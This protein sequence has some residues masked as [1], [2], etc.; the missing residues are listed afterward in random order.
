MANPQTG[1]HGR[2]PWDDFNGTP[3]VQAPAAGTSAVATPAAVPDPWAD[4]YGTPVATPA[5]VQA[6][7]SL[8]PGQRTGMLANVGAAVQEGAAGLVNIA[9]DPVGNIIGKPVVAAG[10]SLYNLGARAFGYDKLTSEQMSAALDDGPGPGDALVAGV[11]RAAGV[12]T[13]ADVVPSTD[14]QHYARAGIQGAVGMAALGPLG[15]LRQIAGT[16]ATGAVSGAGS[17]LAQ[18]ALPS[19]LAPGGA[20]LGGIVAPMLPAVGVTGL[21]GAAGIVKNPLMDYVGP[22]LKTGRNVLADVAPGQPFTPENAFTSESGAPLRASA[23]QARAAGDRLQGA[24]QDPAAT[25]QALAAAPPMATTSDGRP[26]GPTT[27]QLTRDPGLQAAEQDAARGPAAGDF[28]ARAAAQNDANVGAIRGI[29]DGADPAALPGALQHQADETAALHDARVDQ[30]S[31][32]MADDLAAI[33]AQADATRTGLGQ[34][35]DQALQAIGGNLPAGSEAQV[36]ASL[37]APLDTANQAARGSESELW[38]AIDP[39]GTLN[40]DMQPVRAKAQEI[41]RG[42]GP[43]AAPLAGDEAAIMQTAAKLPDV[44]SFRDLADLRGRLTDTIRQERQANGSTPAVA[45]MSQLL[46]GVHEAMTGAANGADLAP[47]ADAAPR[48][49][50]A[51]VAAPSVGGEVFTPSGQRSDVRYEVVDGNNLVTSH[52]HR[53]L[54]PNPA[55]PQELQPRQRERAVSE[56]QVAKIASQL[57][58]ERLGASST[59]A[60]GAPIV[61]PDNLVESGNGRVMGLRRAYDANGPQAQ[62]YRDWL[63]GQGHDTTGMQQPMLIR[64]R[65][66]DMTPE[67]RVAFTREGSTPTTLALSATERAAGDAQRLPDDVLQQVRPGDVAD[68]SNRDFVRGFLQHAVEPGQEG[69]FVTADGGLSQEGAARVRAAL[70]H[71]AYG[72]QGLSAALAETIDPMARVMAGAMQDAVGPMARLRAGIQSG[73]VDPAVDIAPALVEATR[74]VQQSRQKGISLA[75]T[76]AQQDVFNPMSAQA[77]G[78]LRAAYGPELTGRMSQ[79]DFASLLADYAQRAREQSTTANMFGANLSADELLQGSVARY[80]K[81]ASAGTRDAAVDAVPA[82]TVDGAAGGRE[83]GPV[84]SAGGQEAP[85]GRGGQQGANAARVLE[86]PT[87]TANFDAA[88]AE[89]YAAARQATRDRAGTFGNAPGVGDVLKPGPTAGTFRTADQAVPAAI[90]KVGAGGAETA[91]AYLKAGGTAEGLADAAAFS[92]RQSAMK[93]GALDPAAYAKWAKERQSFL[94]QIPD[95]AAKFGAAADAAAAARAGG[96]ALDAHLA[97]AAKV[98]ERTVNDAAAARAAAIKANQDTVAGK[99]L[100]GADPVRQVGAILKSPTA[101]RDAAQLAQLTANDPAARAGLRRAVADYILRDL[102]GNAGSATG[103]ET[104]LDGNRLQTFLRNSKPAL[105]HIMDPGDV[106]ALQSVADSLA[107][108]SLSKQRGAGLSSAPA[109]TSLLQRFTHEIAG[110][111]LGGATGAGI[112]SALAGPVGGYVGSMAGGAMGKV[113]QAAREAGIHNTD[114]L[115][116]QALLNPA[117]MKV[118][119]TKATPQNQATLMGGLAAQLRRVSLVSAV[120]P[121]ISRDQQQ[122]QRQAAAPAFAVRHNDLAAV[123]PGAASYARRPVNSLLR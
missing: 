50:G 38:Q 54:A 48:S 101:E 35:A 51:S 71:R 58:P 26:A 65:T 5:P 23:N 36:G 40:V 18:D 22:A 121:G 16:L 96:K 10:T 53:T 11:D 76:V 37:R 12:P 6:G 19:D 93:D 30:V 7:P 78:L 49:A 1:V 89:R 39:N 98:A 123:S 31:Q 14:A 56:V 46:D 111:V 61:G 104:A 91:K 13:P 52:D 80:G 20:V 116:S 103:L 62:S 27:F 109:S 79:A 77:E 114:H 59:V 113:L 87:L 43:N 24:M 9:A 82:G 81:A 95:A 33:Q 84:P 117:L 21:R 73:Q 70:V 15:G 45:R 47:A 99:F 55:F 29:A 92:L 25:Q 120:Q 122:Q 17:Q 110:T 34:R 4:F 68:P 57:Q 83:G 74:A 69:S 42:I 2:D 72:D 94:S 86:Q 118:L 3:V 115:V 67:E 8:Q 66:T 105:R 97:Q 90:V 32:R 112:G 119:L 88:A 63:A 75:D 100:G 106:T 44:Q 102:K 108:S 28:Q 41:A 85:G 60:D 107:S 64:R